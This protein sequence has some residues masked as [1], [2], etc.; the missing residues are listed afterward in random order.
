MTQSLRRIEA[1]AKPLGRAALA[2][3]ALLALTFTQPTA[4][5]IQSGN[6]AALPGEARHY[7]RRIERNRGFRAAAPAQIA[8]ATVPSLAGASDLRLTRDTDFG[9]VR[10][11]SSTLGYLTPARSGED[12]MTVATDFRADP[13]VQQMLGLRADDLLDYEV[14]DVVPS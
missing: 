9:T 7:D 3:G 5:A 6:A 4:N 2:A 13:A 14:T 10:S 8:A 11:V 1:L 12:A